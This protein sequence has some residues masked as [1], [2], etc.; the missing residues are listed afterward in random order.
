MVSSHALL[1]PAVTKRGTNF[2]PFCGPL[3]NRNAWVS[4][5]LE[6]VKYRRAGSGKKHEEHQMKSSRETFIGSRELYV[7][8]TRHKSCNNQFRIV[9]LDQYGRRNIGK[10]PLHEVLLLLC[11]LP[12]SVI[13]AKK[14]WNGLAFIIVLRLWRI[15]RVV[16]SKYCF[17]FQLI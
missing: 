1:W 12:F 8:K 17:S 6:E 10:G 13:R 11:D 14:A 16:I 9:Y 15:F 3:V 2:S 4:G 7:H 5:C